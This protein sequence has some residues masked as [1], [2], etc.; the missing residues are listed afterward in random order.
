[1]TAAKAESDREAVSAEST[2]NPNINKRLNELET[3][4]LRLE[5]ELSNSQYRRS[6]PTAAATPVT[7]RGSQTPDSATVLVGVR[8]MAP[9]GADIRHKAADASTEFLPGHDMQ[10]RFQVDKASRAAKR[11]HFFIK[12]TKFPGHEQTELNGQV[13]V[14]P[15][16]PATAHY[17]FSHSIPIDIS[18]DEFSDALRGGPILKAIYLPLSAE[19]DTAAIAPVEI[20]SKSDGKTTPA[21]IQE[22]A[23]KGHV[24]A[25]VSLGTSAVTYVGGKEKMTAPPTAREVMQALPEPEAHGFIAQP[26]RD[27]VRITIEQIVKEVDE[28][29][30]YPLLGSAALQRAHFKCTARYHE[31]IKSDWPV[32]F[33]HD[34]G[35]KTSVVYIDHDR[36]IGRP[37]LHDDGNA[38]G[39][40][41][42]G[43]E[44]AQ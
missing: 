33:R 43:V 20:V 35:E 9:K 8:F 22:A 14:E 16:A 36:L 26:H 27:N 1:V 21:A 17:L 32:P 3:K 12:L 15:P 4:I 41:Q 42:S 34:N 40:A 37:S 10:V 23:K 2:A 44:H 39:D 7:V 19:P 5:R 30:H 29:R 31:V 13:C 11:E 18:V 24:L 28:E 6:V 25:L 38:K